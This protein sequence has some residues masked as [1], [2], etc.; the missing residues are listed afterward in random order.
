MRRYVPIKGS[1]GTVIPPMLR[2]EVF[3][4]DDGCVGRLVGFPEPCGSPL[5]IDHVRASH[6]VGM[7]S[8]TEADNLVALCGS[9]H[10]WK[11]EHG[12]EAR[13]QGPASR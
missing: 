9:C 7:K 13:R 5:E 11:T 6:G 2:L 1:R 4:R 10:R 12:R 8:R 3:A